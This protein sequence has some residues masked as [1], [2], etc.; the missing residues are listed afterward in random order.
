MHIDIPVTVTVRKLS[1][2][3]QQMVEIAK[4]MSYN[5]SVLILDEPTS[6]LAQHEVE[7]LF[8]VV[9]KLKAQGR[10]HHLHHP[11]TP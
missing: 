5:P 11:Q 6:A 10:Y 3:Q 7:S 2:G 9:R 4:A 8:A 1:V